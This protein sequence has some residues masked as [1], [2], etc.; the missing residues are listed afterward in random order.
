MYDDGVVEFIV[1]TWEVD[2]VENNKLFR[3]V[4]KMRLSDDIAQQLECAIREGRFVAGHTLP[5]E[6]E[7]AKTFNVSRPIIRE[8][9]RILEIHRFVTIQQGCGTLVKDPDMDILSQPISEWLDKNRQ[10]LDEYYEARQ[11][12]E[13]DCAALAAQRATE[14][15]LQGL[16]ANLEESVQVAQSGENLAALVGLDID[17]HSEIADMS[18]NPFLIKLLNTLIV[19]ESDARKIVLRLPNHIPVML[20]GHQRI[21]AAIKAGDSQAARQAMINALHQPIVAIEALQT[22]KT[23]THD[24]ELGQ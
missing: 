6:R 17:F 22:E 9:L 1:C 14:R 11:A 4:E 3:T 2:S 19:P 24:Q 23:S 16:Q 18:A 21:Y 5:S 20:Q 7:L 13:P 10:W 15:Q 12:I 8:A